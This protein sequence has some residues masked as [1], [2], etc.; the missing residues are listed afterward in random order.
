MSVHEELLFGLNILNCIKRLMNNL[1]LFLLIYSNHNK[2]CILHIH[3][4]TQN[5]V[6]Y[7]HKTALATSVNGMVKVKSA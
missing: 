3:Y 7:L 5:S 4:G 2:T 1:Y 6:I